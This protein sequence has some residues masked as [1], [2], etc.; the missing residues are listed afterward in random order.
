MA[1]DLKVCI[2]KDFI[3]IIDHALICIALLSDPILAEIPRAQGASF[4]PEKACLPG[5]RATILQDIIDWVDSP[6]GAAILWLTGYAGSGNGASHAT[7]LQKLMNL[8]ARPPF[9]IPPHFISTSD[10]D[11]GPP[12]FL[13]RRIELLGGRTI[14]SVPSHAML[15]A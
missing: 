2:R 4:Q 12:S 14:S 9:Y 7:W 15:S 10:V 6:D 5:T 11:S 13:I 1:T 3:N 8:Q